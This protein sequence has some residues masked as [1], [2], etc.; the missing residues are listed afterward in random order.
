MNNGFEI[1]T[2][3]TDF[4]AQDWF[5]GAIKGVILQLAPKV[6]LV[7]IAHGIAPG[8]I[9]AGAFALAAA[10]PFFPPHSIHVAVVDPGVGSPR[11]AIAIQTDRGIFVGPDNGVLSWALR[12]CAIRRVHRL[13]NPRYRAPLV[14]QTFHGRDIFAPAAAHLARGVPLQ[15]LGAKLERFQRLPWPE[16]AASQKQ[17]RGEV[18][19]LDRFGNA[20]TNLANT[21]LDGRRGGWAIR[22]GQ[23]TH[24][25]VRACYAAVPSGKP[26]AVPGSTGFLEIAVNGGN[27]ARA[28]RLRP[29]ALVRLAPDA[30]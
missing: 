13:D 21:L 19:Y 2:L 11:A 10:T 5:V 28:L 8:D 18:L 25:P 26:V 16:V 22:C 9:R 3:T 15:R 14:S 12:A 1:I 6:G 27:A 7:D 30:G 17:F 29:G 23:R 4:G 20:I 24:C